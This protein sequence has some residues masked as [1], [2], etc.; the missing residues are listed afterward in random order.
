MYMD[1]KLA[2][3]SVA[4]RL[5]FEGCSFIARSNDKN[6][7]VT[8]GS[9]VTL[10]WA[11]S[12]W[13]GQES[14]RTLSLPILWVLGGNEPASKRRTCENKLKKNFGEHDIHNHGDVIHD[15]QSRNLSIPRGVS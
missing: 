11:A 1:N 10:E 5:A 7:K 2:M 15:L 12:R 8:W 14:H 3:T 9:K 13:T 6:T 4:I